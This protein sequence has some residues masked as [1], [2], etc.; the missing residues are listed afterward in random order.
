[1]QSRRCRGDGGW[2]KR[3][4]TGRLGLML[5]PTRN[6]QRLPPPSTELHRAERGCALPQGTETE[7][8]AGPCTALCRRLDLWLLSLRTLDPLSTTRGYGVREGRGVGQLSLQWLQLRKSTWGPVKRQKRTAPGALIWGWTLGNVQM[9]QGER[10]HK[11]ETLRRKTG[12]TAEEETM[13]AGV[14][15]KRILDAQ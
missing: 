1:M 13:T 14:Y 3:E 9:S 15:R 2:C 5:M 10:G 12:K 6:L 4:V 8:C 11:G 7:L